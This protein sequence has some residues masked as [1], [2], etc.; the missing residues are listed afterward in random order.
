MMMI[1]NLQKKAN[2]STFNFGDDDDE[3]YI[4]SD[5]DDINDD[6]EDGYIS[7]GEYFYMSHILCLIHTNMNYT[8]CLILLI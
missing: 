5:R 2:F 4:C 3:N 8:L 6:L 7:E 1:L